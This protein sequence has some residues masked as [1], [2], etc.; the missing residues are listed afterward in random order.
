MKPNKNKN[1]GQLYERINKLIMNI[2]STANLIKHKN[3]NSFM[4]HIFSERFEQLQYF[5]QY[6]HM[7]EHIKLGGIQT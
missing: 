5:S 3:D 1:V 2:H 4:I 7:Y 6:S